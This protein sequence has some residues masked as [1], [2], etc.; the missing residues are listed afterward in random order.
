LFGGVETAFNRELRLN[1]NTLVNFNSAT[2]KMGAYIP[3]SFVSGRTAKNFSIGGS[4]NAEQLYYTGIGKNILNNRS[5]DYLNLFLNFSS[6]AQKAK[7][8]IF[9]RWA[10]TL[11]VGYRDALSFTSSHKLVATSNLYF[12]GLFPNHNLVVN[13]AYQKRDTTGDIFSNT[14]PFSRGYQALRTRRMYKMGAN[15]HFP[16]LYPDCGVGNIAYLLRIRANAFFDYTNA[17]ARLNGTLQDIIAKT[18]GG[19]IYFDGKI[20]NALPV[21]IGVRYSRLLNNDLL[22]PG[23][24]NVWEVVLPIGII[25]N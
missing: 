25:P 11:S 18:A 17:R 2:A 22:N 3:L 1:N 12:P 15:Y 4:F 8:H 7:Q 16:L 13:L 10:Q 14:F 24:R 9:P 5:F 6:T 21:S 20:W 23:V 19:E